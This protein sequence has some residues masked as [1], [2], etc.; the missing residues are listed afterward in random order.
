MQALVGVSEALNQPCFQHR[1]GISYVYNL[2]VAV[3]QKGDD[4]DSSYNYP[5]QFPKVGYQ[6]MKFDSPGQECCKDKGDETNPE[7]MEKQQ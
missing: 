7:L 5:V 2:R 1:R 4:L 6:D 3:M